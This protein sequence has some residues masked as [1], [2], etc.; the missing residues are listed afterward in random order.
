MLGQKSCKMQSDT[1]AT[2]SI[3][4]KV[5]YDQLFNQWPL[6]GTKI[7]LNAYS[8]IRI[9]VYGEVHLL[10]V[11]EQQELVLPLIVVYGDGPPLFGR[12]WLE[13]LKL[14][15]GNIFHVSKVDTLSDVLDC[16]KMVFN[17]GMG[18]IKGFTTDIKL[19]DGAKP[20]FCKARP[21]LYALRQKGGRRVRPFGEVR[22]REEGGTE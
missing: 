1:G 3:L 20:I 22:S 12:N 14:N 13:Q 4:P 11:Y 19:Q 6:R 8:C 7:K 5:L 10:V 17:K 15:W 9:P 2:V 16:H 18:T 21:V